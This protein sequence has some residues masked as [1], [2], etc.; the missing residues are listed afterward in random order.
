MNHK[1]E[2]V[3]FPLLQLDCSIYSV[4]P[5]AISIFTCIPFFISIPSFPPFLPSSS[6]RQDDM[7][8]FSPAPTQTCCLDPFSTHPLK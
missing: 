3:L 8:T 5:T 7:K 4:M 6:E 2:S 1:H